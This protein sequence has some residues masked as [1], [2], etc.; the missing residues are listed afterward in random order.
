MTGIDLAYHLRRLFE[1]CGISTV[2]DVGANLGQYRNFLRR[3]CGFTGWIFSFEPVS[4]VFEVLRSRAVDDSRWE[5][6]QCAL[7]SE[8]GWREFN[9][10][11][12]SHFSSF[13]DP[14]DD[15]ATPE[16]KSL[17][18]VVRRDVV[19]V[20]RL[21]KI[22][23]EL[24]T[25]HGLGQVYL[26]MDTQGHDNQVMRGAGEELSKIAALQSEVAVRQLY[27]GMTG[28]AASI[29]AIGAYGFEITGIFPVA[30]D[31]MLRVLEFD[32]VAIN[33]RLAG[34]WGGPL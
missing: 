28:F 5:V 7:G 22:L 23:G 12:D 31:N 15:S 32:L 24:R 9:V 19:Q 25:R 21:D 10:M 34:C 18:K 3:K 30:Q 6:F 26:K 14:V 2:L 16:I 13:Y 33:I 8:D 17:N 1:R 20:R 27:R 29:E 4:E 11:N